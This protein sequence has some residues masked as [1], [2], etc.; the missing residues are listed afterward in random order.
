MLLVEFR[1]MGTPLPKIEPGADCTQC[2]GAGKPFGDGPTPKYITVLIA[3]VV[4]GPLW[5]STDP[6]LPN[7][8]Y[9]CK[10]QLSPCLWKITV[11]DW[12]CAVSTL[13]VGTTVSVQY[14]LAKLGYQHSTP[15]LC[16][17]SGFNQNQDYIHHFVGGTHNISWGS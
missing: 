6:E 8:S 16:V 17:S 4:K 15:D 5:V 7:G 14:P 12:S 10:Q 3:G 1:S 9:F 11:G 2:W 13:H